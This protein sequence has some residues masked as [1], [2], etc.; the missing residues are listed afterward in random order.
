MKI[1]GCLVNVSKPPY[2]LQFVEVEEEKLDDYYKLLDCNC[3]DIV[4]RRIGD[5]SFSIVCDDEGLCK[6]N[7]TISAVNKNGKPMLV[8]NL[9]ICK[10][11]APYLASI[12]E[13][14]LLWLSGHVAL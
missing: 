4:D 6:E 2:G 11:N 8:G 7:P 1:K 14:D 12:S 10:N 9:F 5:R 3:I 13:D